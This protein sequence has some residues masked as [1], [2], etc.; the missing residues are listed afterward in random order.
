[1]LEAYYAAHGWEHERHDD[2]I[3]ATVKGSW[4]TYELRALWRED[5]SVLQFLAFPDIKVTDDRRG[6]VYEA[7]VT[8]LAEGS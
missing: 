7:I 4:T 6:G 1:M 8:T 2:E 3:F 5:D